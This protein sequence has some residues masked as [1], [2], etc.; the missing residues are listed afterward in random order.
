VPVLQLADIEE[1]RMTEVIG[2]TPAGRGERV[3]EFHRD[4]SRVSIWLHP[5]G[6]SKDAG[7]Q[8]IVDL[9][10]LVA[11]L[12]NERILGESRSSI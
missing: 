4:G 11:A 1:Y 10:M 8:A 7:W 5:P 6:S 12:E 9:E 2:M 3:V